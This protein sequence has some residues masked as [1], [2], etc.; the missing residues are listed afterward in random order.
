MRKAGILLHISSLPSRWGIGDFG[1]ESIRFASFLNKAGISLWQILPITPIEEIM[2]NSPYS[3]TSA[4]AGNILFISPE[5][6][7]NSGYLDKND[8]LLSDPP[9]FSNEKVDFVK[10][11]EFKHK[12]LHK[13]FERFKKIGDCSDYEL[14]FNQNQYWVESWS[15]FTALKKINKG[16]AWYDWDAGL[17]FRT[18]EALNNAWLEY[19][20]EIEY[21][22]FVQYIFFQQAKVFRKALN[23]LEIELVGDVPIYTTLDSAD[24]WVKPWLFQLN[25]EMHPTC[26]A[27]VPPDYFSK[28]G[29]LWGNPLYNWDKM[30]EDN[31]SWWISRLHH[32]LQLFNYLRIDHFR[33]LIGY[34]SVPYLEKTAENG[35]WQA[36]PHREFFKALRQ[37]LPNGKFWAENLGIITQDVTSVMKDMEFPGMLI[38]QFAWNEPGSNYYAPHNHT[39]ENVVY[40][41][42]HDNNTTL[43]WFMNDATEEEIRNLSSYI[44]KD[45]NQNNICDEL[46][47]LTF[48]S[49]ADYAVIPMQDLL[50]LGTEARINVPSTAK[51]NWSWRMLPDA[52]SETLAQDILKKAIIYGRSQAKHDTEIES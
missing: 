19:Q 37:G 1:P 10:A 52:A 29:Q 41:G 5:L 16:K 40:T 11:R 9:K 22:R 27:G 51:D 13:A 23:S 8:P 17:K 42:T 45:L 33:G 15:F 14:F 12:L 7:V 32:S 24:V 25:E 38:M 30:R 48:S 21:E 46:I 28:T 36:V 4:F 2:G 26:V 39:K 49:I 35:A 6:L 34:W 20:N 50:R 3:P 31:F 18:H 43:G 47:R 44:G